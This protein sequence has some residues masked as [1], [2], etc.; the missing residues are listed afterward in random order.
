MKDLKELYKE[1][2]YTINSHIIKNIK[3]LNISLEEFLLLLYFINEEALLNPEKIEARIGLKVEEV[4][5][6]YMSLTKK[7][8]ISTKVEKENGKVTESICLDSFYDKLILKQED[9]KDNSVD[10]YSVF[11]NEFGRSLSPIEYET[12]NRWLD[13]KVS[14]ETI[15]S[16]LKEAVINGVCNLRYIDKL[17][18]EW[19]KK[20]SKENIE[21]YKELFDY[22]WLGDGDIDE[23][24]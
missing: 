16:A 22:D 24:E 14:E 7:G 3:S 23:E 19:T 9:D 6:T 17:I 10:I 1:K 11:E 4:L 21:E 12:I 8:I 15:K 18:Y 13:N 5:D 20:G 2:N